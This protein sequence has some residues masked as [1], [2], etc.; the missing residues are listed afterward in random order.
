M[1]QMYILINV[2][3]VNIHQ[4]ILNDIKRRELY[5]SKAS[6]WLGLYVQK[7]QIKQYTL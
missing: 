1:I 2:S 3:S 6:I 7:I 4:I 5:L